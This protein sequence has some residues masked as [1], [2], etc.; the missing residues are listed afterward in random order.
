DRVYVSP[1]A[2]LEYLPREKARAKLQ[3][4]GEVVKKVGA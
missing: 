3:R 1:S 2:G 4:L